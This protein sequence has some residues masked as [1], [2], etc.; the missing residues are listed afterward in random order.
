MVTWKEVPGG[1]HSSQGSSAVGCIPDPTINL[2]QAISQFHG[3]RNLKSG[4]WEL[5]ISEVL[6]RVGKLGPRVIDRGRVQVE[7]KI[8]H[9]LRPGPKCRCF[10][11]RGHHILQVPN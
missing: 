7:V 5:S 3:S 11:R 1:K 8:S 4:V 6:K 2:S 9:E 10:H